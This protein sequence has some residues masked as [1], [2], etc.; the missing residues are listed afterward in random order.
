MDLFST[1][2]IT[3]EDADYNQAKRALPI[4][5]SMGFVN[6]QSEIRAHQTI[7][8]LYENPEFKVIGRKSAEP[9]LS[10][11]DGSAILTLKGAESQLRNAKLAKNHE[12]SIRE[13]AALE[14][15]KR[16]YEQ[17]VEATP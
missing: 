10:T 16:M 12:P 13:V 17:Q 1:E 14:A 9:T 5:M 11:N 3:S 7:V 4:L 8:H 6:V 2:V 15:A